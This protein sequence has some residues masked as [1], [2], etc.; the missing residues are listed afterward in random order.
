MHTHAHTT[1]TKFK[2]KRKGEND[3][4]APVHAPVDTKMKMVQYSQGDTLL[5]SL[6]AMGH[7][8]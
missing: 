4:N 5:F 2:K 1:A 6:E 7:T 3:F 8:R